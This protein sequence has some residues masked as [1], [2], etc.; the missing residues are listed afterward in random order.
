VVPRI[1]DA[2]ERFKSLT[3][4]EQQRIVDGQHPPLPEPGLGIL[5]AA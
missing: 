5:P 2:A 4:E 1:L 3:A